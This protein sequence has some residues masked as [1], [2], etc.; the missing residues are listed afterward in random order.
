[1]KSIKL[2][3]IDLNLL[4]AFEA[5]FKE[6]SVTLAAQR[7]YLGQPATSAALGRLRTLFNDEL[8]IRVGREMRP[9]AKAQMIA[10]GIF[11]ALQQVRQTLQSHQ[12]FEAALDSRS[13]AIGSADYM[14][15]VLLPKLIAH[16]QQAAPYLNFRIIEFEKDLV[17]DLLEKGTVDLAIG[18]FPHPPRQFLCLPLFQECF[19]GIARKNH[20]A[21]IQKPITLD[22]FANL[23]HA[24]HTIRRDEIGVIDRVLAKHNLQRR[25]ALTVPHMLVLPSIIASTDLI[26]VIPARMA[27]YFSRINE[28][29]VFDLPINLDPWTISMLWSQL[30]DNDEAGRWLRQT[31]QT[32]CEKI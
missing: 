27:Q 24:L 12:N 25:V 21:L 17:G 1:M 18:V 26:T 4:V 15:F 13:L 5:L 32:L 28:I 16:C 7:L 19:V 29:E 30:S 10:P 11:A 23:S 31:L 6:R 14:S 2:A 3:Q 8:F 20:P 9:T 22:V